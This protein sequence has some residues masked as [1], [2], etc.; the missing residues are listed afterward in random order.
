[1]DAKDRDHWRL[2]INVKLA[3]P[4]LPRKKVKMV[5]VSV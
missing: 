2:K 4:G 5:W 1:M 3:N